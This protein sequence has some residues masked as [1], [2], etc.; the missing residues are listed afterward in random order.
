[1]HPFWRM[2]GPRAPESCR[3]GPKRHLWRLSFV[4][5]K[6]CATKERDGEP[7]PMLRGRSQCPWR[8]SFAMRKFRARAETNRSPTSPGERDAAMVEM[9]L[10]AY[11][12]LDV[13]ELSSLGI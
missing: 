8:L 13:P 9:A 1:M 6:D 5:R 3:T 12:I 10:Q 11:A 2:P 4:Q 7:R